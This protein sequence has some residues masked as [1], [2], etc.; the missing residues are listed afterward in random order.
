MFDTTALVCFFILLTV[1][2]CLSNGGGD[3]LSLH[4][5]TPD[6]QV[7]QLAFATRAIDRGPPRISFRDHDTGI[8]T[9]FAMG[10]LPS[11]L[12]DRMKPAIEVNPDISVAFTT[13]GYGP[14]VSYLLNKLNNIVQAHCKTYGEAPNLD[15]LSFHLSSWVTSGMYKQNK[16]DKLS[17]PLAVAVAIAAYDRAFK[18]NRLVLVDNTGY[19]ADTSS[20]LLGR[21]TDTDRDTITA[22][23]TSAPQPSEQSPHPLSLTKNH[24]LDR[25][26]K[27]C[28]TCLTTL[29][30]EEDAEF[31][32]Q[33]L[34]CCILD[35]HGTVYRTSRPLRTVAETVDW[36]KKTV[37]NDNFCVSE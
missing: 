32:T 4:S 36:I 31:A 21:F 37:H 25:W 15:F 18:R 7:E 19:S 13:A 27:K 5:Y 34:D 6:G 8:V 35:A 11:S 26:Q 30:Q 22:A 33:V 23:L 10:D 1:A 17:R 2:T 9:S 29:I 28:H 14:D 3:D 20:S 12:R 24:K 16:E